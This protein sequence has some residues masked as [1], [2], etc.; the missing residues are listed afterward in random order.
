MTVQ[1]NLSDRECFSHGQ[2]VSQ[3]HARVLP[4]SQRHHRVS[5]FCGNKMNFQC[6]AESDCYGH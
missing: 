6:I 2:D 5:Y 1:G 3:G 4:G